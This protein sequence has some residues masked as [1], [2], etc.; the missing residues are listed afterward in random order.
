[1]RFGTVTLFGRSNVGKSTFLNAV[2]EHDLS[3]VSPLPQTTRDALLGV[4]TLYRHGTNRPFVHEEIELIADFSA[5]A[6][7][8]LDNA[9]TR[10]ELELLATTDDLTGLPNRRR[11]RSELEREIAAALCAA[12]AWHSRMTP[13]ARRPLCLL[14]LQNRSVPARRSR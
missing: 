6:A 9:R 1:M 3:I 8:S 10:S 14:R 11:F 4:L 2:L 13:S 5:V 7:L 12:P